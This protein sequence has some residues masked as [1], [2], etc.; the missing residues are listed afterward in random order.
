M[1]SLAE[2]DDVQGVGVVR[3]VRLN[4]RPAVL[5][6]VGRAAARAGVRPR[7]LATF[8][9]LLEFVLCRV[10]RLRAAAPEVIRLSVAK[11]RPHRR[12]PSKHVPH[13]LPRHPEASRDLLAGLARLVVSYCL[14]FLRLG[15]P[16]LHERP[17]SRT[18]RG[19]ALA[20]R[21]A[22]RGRPRIARRLASRPARGRGRFRRR[23]RRAI[24]H[25][26]SPPDARE[27]RIEPRC[28]LADAPQSQ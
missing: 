15:Q 8:D 23:R 27:L 24:R 2:P 7:N 13:R 9:R 18:L 3:V 1:A 25:S 19:T 14:P 4:R 21:L 22:G 12:A 17:R 11:V 5:E 10:L 16:Q 26:R 20:G 6:S 28:E